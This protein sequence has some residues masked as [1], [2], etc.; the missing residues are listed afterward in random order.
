VGVHLAGQA[1]PQQEIAPAVAAVGPE[2]MPAEMRF[3]GN[4]N[5]PELSQRRALVGKRKQ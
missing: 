5:A 2:L 3:A 4:F 1:P